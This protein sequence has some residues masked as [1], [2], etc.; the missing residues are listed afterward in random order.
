M[1]GDMIRHQNQAIINQLAQT[2]QVNLANLA[3]VER[4]YQEADRVYHRPNETVYETVR[5]TVEI[6]NFR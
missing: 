6:Y 3:H 4:Y 2:G 5:T 1:N